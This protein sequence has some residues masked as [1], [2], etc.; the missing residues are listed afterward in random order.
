MVMFPVPTL[1]TL[2]GVPVSWFS[3]TI[4]LD[5]TVRSSRSSMRGRE[6]ER[7]PTGGHP[8]RRPQRARRN[9]QRVTKNPL[10][11]HAVCV[12]NQ[13]VSTGAQTGRLGDVRPVRAL[14]GG[15]TS[16]VTSL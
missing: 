14:L 11:Q 2:C 5:R 4:A 8:R 10:L 13:G 6:E 7:T 16:P 3:A 12:Y 1:Q 15:E 9:M